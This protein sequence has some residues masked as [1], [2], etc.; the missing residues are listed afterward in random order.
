ME[1]RLDYK[2]DVFAPK[3]GF[4]GCQ[5][6]TI[7]FRRESIF[8]ETYSC[9]NEIVHLEIIEFNHLNQQY[10]INPIYTESPSLNFDLVTYL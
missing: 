2:L 9:N 6:L 8:G 4:L 5:P 3:S 7:F 1:P 10:T